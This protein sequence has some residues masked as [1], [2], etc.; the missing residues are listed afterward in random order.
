MRTASRVPTSS[1]MVAMASL[2]Y[3]GAL[4]YG[5][6]LPNCLTLA[7]SRQKQQASSRSLSG[8]STPDAKTRL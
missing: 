3:S 6:K 5:V 8:S 4:R 2:A 7:E 1:G